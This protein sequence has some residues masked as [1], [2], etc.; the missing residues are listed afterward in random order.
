MNKRSSTTQ[1]HYI[2]QMF[3]KY[4][5]HGLLRMLLWLCSQP[6][7]NSDRPL[8]CIVKFKYYEHNMNGDN[9]TEHH[10]TTK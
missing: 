10:M 7:H 4:Y 8:Q 6:R 5:Y 1:I 9:L 2:D 3:F